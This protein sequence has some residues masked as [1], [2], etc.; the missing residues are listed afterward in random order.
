MPPPKQN[1]TKPSTSHS[2][3]NNSTIPKSE[4]AISTATSIQLPILLVIPYTYTHTYTKKLA[5]TISGDKEKQQ[6]HNPFTMEEE[7]ARLVFDICSAPSGN[8]EPTTKR[9]TL[10]LQPEKKMVRLQLGNASSASSASSCCSLPRLQ[11]KLGRSLMEP[12]RALSRGISV[13]PDRRASST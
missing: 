10:Q 6:I 2:S 9:C 11:Q 4:S 13:S 8:P 12:Q 7:V 3:T 5:S 1:K